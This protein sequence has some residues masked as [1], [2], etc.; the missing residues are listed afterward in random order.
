MPKPENVK[1]ET[2]VFFEGLDEME[3]LCCRSAPTP[4]H[5][6]EPQSTGP[7][8]DTS[9]RPVVGVE[10]FCG[11]WADIWPGSTWTVKDRDFSAPVKWHHEDDDEPGG[12]ADRACEAGLKPVTEEKR[13]ILDRLMANSGMIPLQPDGAAL[14]R[15]GGQPY[16]Q[17][18]EH[19]YPGQLVGLD[20][21]GKLVR[22]ANGGE[23]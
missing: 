12:L 4:W 8:C 6:A 9:W 1:C 7:T 2:C 10:E 19:L 18:A 21:N 23:A 3:G 5:G 20:E 15:A 16:G 17:A 13:E 22:W 11:E 14:F